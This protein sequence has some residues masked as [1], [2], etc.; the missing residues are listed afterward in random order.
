MHLER[1]QTNQGTNGTISASVT[2]VFSYLNQYCFGLSYSVVGGG[3][4]YSAPFLSSAQ[5][6][7]AYSAT[8]FSS[9]TN[10]WLDAGS[11]WSITNPLS[12]STSSERWQT[13]LLLA[14]PLVLLRQQVQEAGLPSLS[15][16]IRSRSS[17]RSPEVA[18]D[19][20]RQQQLTLSSAAVIP[21]LQSPVQVHQSG[22]TLAQHTLIQTR[23]LD[24]VQQQWATSNASGSA[25]AAITVSKT[26]Y[27]QYS[28]ASSFAVSGGGSAY[29]SS[30]LVINP[31]W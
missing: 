15:T 9:A 14:E 30:P 7:S 5:F 31:V 25:S 24:R 20:L 23:S 19:T 21:S 10:F 4:G 27:N 17:T 3:T 28:F 11:S 26:Y 8:L 13:S 12:G 29:S 22:L 6:G 18:L 16:S 1:W 2:T